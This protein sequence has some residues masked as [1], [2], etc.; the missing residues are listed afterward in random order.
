MRA[1]IKSEW[2]NSSLL[3]K[4]INF[5]SIILILT[6]FI[7]II[8]IFSN[9]N[10]ALE[11]ELEIIKSHLNI[12][13]KFDETFPGKWRHYLREMSDI[14]ELK[15]DL[16]ELSGSDIK[17]QNEDGNIILTGQINSI[18]ELVNIT[19]HLYNFRGLVINRL[20]IDK[21]SE[22]LISFKLSLIF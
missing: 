11:E 15:K 18:R 20:E 2:A 14:P 10:N 17:I 1:Y 5:F 12:I 8:N 3:I 19:S 4:I 13:E 6:S 7:F 9:N 22:D 16:I 21:I